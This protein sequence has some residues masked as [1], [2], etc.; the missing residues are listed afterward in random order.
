MS[1][2]YCVALWTRLLHSPVQPIGEVGAPMAEVRSLPGEA[3]R[4]LPE[5]WA[6]WHPAP[7]LG[8]V[9]H[10]QAEFPPLDF[11]SQAPSMPPSSPALGD[12]T[13]Q[14]R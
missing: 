8:Q 10:Q 13:T 5:P 14:T 6:A 1:F 3:C 12:T 9:G 2:A 11:A 4:G 7:A